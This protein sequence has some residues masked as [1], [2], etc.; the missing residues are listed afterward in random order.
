MMVRLKSLFANLLSKAYGRIFSRNLSAHKIDW[1]SRAELL[2]E[3]S[4]L[5]S[6]D[7]QGASPA[8]AASQ[9]ARYEKF[10]TTLSQTGRAKVALDY[11]CGVGRFTSYMP[12]EYESIIGYDPTNRLIEIARHK[13]VDTRVDFT[14]DFG[15]VVK[16]SPYDLIF[17]AMCSVVYL[18][19]R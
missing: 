4:A 6:M 13:A 1:V 10:L 5:Y 18:T 19:L 12:T 15:D 8:A 7:P 16:S 9:F 3:F 11:G 14:S 17:I 2:G